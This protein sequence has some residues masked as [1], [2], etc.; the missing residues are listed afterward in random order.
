MKIEAVMTRHVEYAAPGDPAS[1]LAVMMGELDVGALPIGSDE[2]L[3]GVVTDRDIL[4]RVVARGL[5]PAQVEARDIL[6]SPVIACRESDDL[7]TAMDLMA[8]NH[9]RRLAVRSEGGRVVGWVTL[10]DLSRKLLLDS[11]TVQDGLAEI[12]RGSVG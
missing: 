5:H 7:Q 8:A 3:L 4:Y 9:V 11:R 10:A 1:E 2:E 12:S 6:S